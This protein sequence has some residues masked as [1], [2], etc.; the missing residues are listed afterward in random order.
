MIE[1]T[2][3]EWGDVEKHSPVVTDWNS[4]YRER[5]VVQEQPSQRVVEA[6]RLFR[7]D[8]ANRILDLGCGTGRHTNY[9]LRKGFEICGCDSSDDALRIA[10]GALP[11]VQFWLCD[12][13]SLPCKN[14]AF[15]GVLCH[16]VVQHGTI[17]TIRKAVLEVQ[18]VL[19][20]GG[21]L[22]LTVPSTEHPEY[23]TGEEIE[24][25]TKMNIDAIDGAMPH[26]YFTEAEMR[27]LFK[28]Y[29][30][31]RLEHHLGSSEKDPSRVAATWALHA[32]RL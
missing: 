14:G 21:I 19:R 13:T 31:L 20:P 25:N 28:G 27:A 3:R 6:A 16:A 8:G 32:K 23:L 2:A 15:D 11:E 22:F 7:A 5:G 29:E 17:H 4:L 26:H 30:I 18:R 1:M 9:V 12:M 24:P 10:R